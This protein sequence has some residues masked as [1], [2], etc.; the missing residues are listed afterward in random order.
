MGLNI[1]KAKMRNN[2]FIIHNNTKSFD[3]YE[4][5]A[6]ISHCMQKGLLSNNETEYCYCTVQQYEFCD[7]ICEFKKTKNNYR[8]NLY[9]KERKK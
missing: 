3:D 4:L 8:I 2:K 9:E 6:F 1:R 5:F 7:L